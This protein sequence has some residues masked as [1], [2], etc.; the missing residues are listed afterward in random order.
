MRMVAHDGVEAPACL[1]RCVK[2]T[3]PRH[4][5]GAMILSNQRARGY[6][7]LAVQWSVVPDPKSDAGGSG[8]RQQR[9]YA[10]SG[11]LTYS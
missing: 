2:G 10:V 9:R 4:A 8:G 1:R 11:A 6:C 5:Y 7:E 3:E